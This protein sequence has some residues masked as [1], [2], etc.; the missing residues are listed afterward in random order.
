M[1]KIARL[2][3]LS[4]LLAASTLATADDSTDK[5][6]ALLQGLT[7]L[8]AKKSQDVADL[9]QALTIDMPVT[10][11]PATFVLG[12]AG[13]AVPRVSTWKKFAADAGSA[14]DDNGKIAKAVAFEINPYLAAGPVSWTAYR[15][16][17]DVQILTRTTLSVATKTGSD[18]GSAQSAFGVQST[19]YS[20]E[21]AAAI[22]QARSDE[23]VAVAERFARENLGTVSGS[24]NVGQDLSEPGTAQGAAE[25]QAKKDQAKKDQANVDNCRKR[26][27]ALLT[28]WNPTSVAVGFGQSFYSSSAT[29]RGLKNYGSGVWITGTYG[30]D[31]DGQDTAAQDR[32]GIGLTL[33]LRRMTG[34]RITSP[35][36]SSVVVSENINIAGLNM[37]LG[38]A[39]W[40]VIAEGSLSKGKA[41]TLSDEN[42]KRAVLAAEYKISDGLYVSLGIGNDTGRR[43]GKDQHVTLASLKW[44]FGDQPVLTK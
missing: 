13:T 41:H 1:C 43:D 32:R 39:H 24:V 20:K 27:S 30:I 14:L 26:L 23:C 7:A 5:D 2:G 15:K 6:D 12:A 28:K 44:G 42:R 38:N 29:V 8:G 33:H 9:V 18:D 10:T 17:I 37:R 19:L 11:S 4:T 36:D 16:R 25:D 22:V 40:G 31:F 34:Q 3:V 21:A 35:D